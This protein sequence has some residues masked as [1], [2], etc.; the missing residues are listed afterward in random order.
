MGYFIQSIQSSACHIKNT[1]RKKIAK[2]KSP[3]Q[4]EAK[5]Q[6][7]SGTSTTITQ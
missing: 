1:Q 2:S 7:P 4:L 5:G 3:A 6:L